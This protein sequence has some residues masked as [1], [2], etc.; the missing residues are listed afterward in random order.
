[1]KEQSGLRR[2][3]CVSE[4]SAVWGTLL[5][6][7]SGSLAAQIGGD[8]TDGVFHPNSNVV[9]DTTQ[10][11]NGFHFKSITIP[12][13]V[14]V[15]LVGTHPAILRSLGA[16]EIAGMLHANGSQGTVPTGGAPGAGGYAGGS[17][18][19]SNGPI[20]TKGSGP[21]GG[22]PGLAQIFKGGGGAPGQHR[23]VYGSAWP[24]DLR[25]GSGAGGTSLRLG[26]GPGGGGGGGTIVVLAD[27][28]VNLTG[29]VTS[30]GGG[31]G[32]AQ[33]YGEGAAGSIMIRSLTDL[34]VSGHI[35]ATGKGAWP[36]TSG[37]GFVRLD[38]YGKLPTITGT[39]RP[40]P[41]TLGMPALREVA[42]LT[43]GQAWRLAAGAVPGDD[44][45]FFASPKPARLALP[46]LGILQ[47]D[48]GTMFLLG[49]ARVSTTG[50]DPVAELAVP[51]P[52]RPTLRGTWA[53]VQ[54]ISPNTTLAVGPKL[55]N[56]IASRVK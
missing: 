32:S 40:A 53:Y 27:G 36:R 19:G 44:V 9:L 26:T 54:T 25:G 33:G 7:L 17:G 18:G 55:S 4:K 48:P 43:I 46:P 24:F 28:T 2:C 42:P 51:I 16:V 39:V 31:V 35:D 30:R 50:H 41:E 52:N 15:A 45:W 5:W 49:S 34:R 37:D 23:T 56:H 14:T 47:I 21:G 1:M 8:G 6:V 10:R 20:A 13:G 38:C 22:A 12:T 11:P 3:R 29:R